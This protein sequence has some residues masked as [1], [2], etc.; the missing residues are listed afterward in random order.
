MAI[1]KDSH[2]ALLQQLKDPFD[3]RL[4]KWRQGGGNT[5]LAYIDARDVMKRLDDIVGI[6]NWQDKYHEVDG[7][8]ICE[9]SIKIDDEWVT[10]S[11]GANRSKIEPVKGGISGA[12]KRAAAEW[13]IGRYLY[14]IPNAYAARD[15]S[16]W[17]TKFLPGAPE[18]WEDIAQ[19]EAE[20]NT[21]VDAELE[22]MVRKETI[23]LIAQITATES[24]AELDKL[25][26][27]LDSEQ[28]LE[29]ADF[30]NTKK[31]DLLHA[32]RLES[33]T[34]QSSAKKS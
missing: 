7:G 23:D 16:E 11:N 6:A 8:I 10:K 24:Q 21:G 5:T 26:K 31:R 9:L 15:H 22:S 30:I 4:V 18:N 14:Y 29:L 27:T 34:S 17:D 20:A 13:G 28:Q 19:M 12:L 3:P 2:K 33:D 25:T 32:S 1:N